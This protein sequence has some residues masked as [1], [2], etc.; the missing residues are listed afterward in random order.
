MFITSIDKFKEVCHNIILSF[1]KVIPFHYSPDD[2]KRRFIYAKDRTR[3]IIKV[4]LMSVSLAVVNR[5]SRS[6]LRSIIQ[7]NERLAE[8]KRFLKE[9]SGSKF[10]EDRRSSKT[11]EFVGPQLYKKAVAPSDPYVPLGNILLKKKI[12][13]PD[14]LDEALNLHWRRGI[15]F[16]EV[17]KELGF[18]KEEELHEALR[19]QYAS[20]HHPS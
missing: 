13:T 8:I 15:L 18:I 5:E 17:L 14:Q 1:D 11:G 6:E 9:I 2:R 3:K 19:E 4:D 16:G 7:I 12:L 10:M 20:K